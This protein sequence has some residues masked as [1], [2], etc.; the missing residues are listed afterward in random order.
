MVARAKLEA[1]TQRFLTRG[2]SEPVK[3]AERDR[4]YLGRSSSAT[5]G[6]IQSSPLRLVV[7]NDPEADPQQPEPQPAEGDG[8][9]NDDGNES[10]SD[11]EEMPEDIAA[12]PP[13]QQQRAIKIRACWQMALGTTLVLI[14]SDPMVDCLSALGE[15]TGISPFYISFVLAP[16]ASN[17]SELLAAYKF[18]L[19]KTQATITVS[20]S[21]LEGAAIMNNTFCLGIFMVLIYLQNLVWVRLTCVLCVRVC[22]Y[23]CC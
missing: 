17:A 2:S 1:H 15:R 14:F 12:L 19:K 6:S 20:L 5:T 22:G 3:A 13:H 7:A 23:C 18:A 10:D 4:P 11:E 9:G 8:D 16:L 21:Q